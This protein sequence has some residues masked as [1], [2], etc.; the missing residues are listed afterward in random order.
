METDKSTTKVRVF[1]YPWYH[2]RLTIHIPL[3]EFVKVDVILS[4]QFEL[5]DTQ[6]FR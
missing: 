2:Q 1:G 5:S 6:L 4:N 3:L